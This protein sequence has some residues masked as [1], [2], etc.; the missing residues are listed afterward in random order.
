MRNRTG[1]RAETATGHLA[2]RPTA[3]SSPLSALPKK[4]VNRTPRSSLCSRWRAAIR[5]S[6]RALSKAPAA[7]LVAGRKV[8]RVRQRDKP[9]RPREKRQ[10]TPAEHDSDVRVIT[11][12]VYRSNGSGY[13]DYTHPQHLWIVSAPRTAE[14]KVKPKQITSGQFS[15]GDF[16]WSKDG[17]TVYFTSDR[18]AEPYYELQPTTI[19]SVAATGGEPARITS[20]DVSSGS[21]SLSPD[22]KRFAFVGSPNKPVNSYT[23][24]D[25]WVVDL[26]QGAQPQ[27]LDDRL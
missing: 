23:Q 13:I 24:P 15:E 7:C 2:G 19:Y 26:A 21:L 17:S 9:R 14:D 12:A 10:K 11:R 27:E 4:T 20:F 3:N 16:N 18:V 8:D 1:S 6:S 5:G 22:G 25:L